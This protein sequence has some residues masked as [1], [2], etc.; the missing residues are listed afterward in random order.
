MPC[1]ICNS[2]TKS[3]DFTDQRGVR[4]QG[5]YK[6]CF[7]CKGV[8]LPNQWKC[9]YMNC[10]RHISKAYATCFQHN[11][12]VMFHPCVDCGEGFNAKYTLAMRTNG[13]RC[14]A[15]YRKKQQENAADDI[16]HLLGVN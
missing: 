9:G 2:E 15:C 13:A 11:N 4:R 5:T 3:Y 1:E 7:D 12:L 14:P 16:K 6:R 10:P 8:L